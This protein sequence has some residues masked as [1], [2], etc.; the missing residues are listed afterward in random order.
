MQKLALFDLDNTLLTGDSDHAWGLFLASINAV[1][2]KK[3]TKAQ[4]KFY[5][6]YQQ[7][8]LDIFE[9]LEFQF[10]PLKENDLKNLEKWREQYI[11][12]HIK[13]MITQTRLDLV[14]LH[15]DLE[16]ELI[17][18]TATN[19]F[20]TRPIADLFG[21]EHLIATEPEKNTHGF[22]GKLSGTPCFQEGKIE[23]LNQFLSE[24]YSPNS[25]IADYESWFYSDSHNDLPLL[26]EVTRPVAVTPDNS[27]REY[28]TQQK[29]KIID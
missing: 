7:G 26:K 5:Q 21:I 1:D 29:W 20:I 27:L 22:T 13:P 12:S 10:T 11:E 25:S 28:A 18:I 17:I 15:Q 3:Q 14:K 9:F 6:Q 19:S 4:D 8:N 23:K 24:H 16:H 2:A